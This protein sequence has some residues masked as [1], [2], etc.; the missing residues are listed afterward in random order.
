[1]AFINVP[2]EFTKDTAEI[3]ANAGSG[4]LPLIPAGDYVGVFLKSEMKETS[5]G[6]QMLVLT[7]VITQGEHRDTEFTE[8]LNIINSN[9]IATKIAY[10]TLAKISKAVGLVKIPS[11]SAA[12]HNKPMVWKIK[13]EAG[14]P[15]QD[16]ITGETRQGNA[17]SV[18]SGFDALPS[19]AAGS[20]TP[21]HG[22]QPTTSPAAQSGAFWASI[23]K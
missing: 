12:L 8:R 6:G 10:E 7:G 20:V 11:D 4:G 2:Q 15:Y 16:K 23:A 19:G 13:T 18:L 17:K 1:M 14:K 5:T 9:P 21:L 3:V 22:G